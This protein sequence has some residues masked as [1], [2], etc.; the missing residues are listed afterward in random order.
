[1]PKTKS[2]R[3]RAYLVPHH[4]NEAKMR[5][6][7]DLLP[8]WQRGLV[9]MQHLQVRRMRAGIRPSN[10]STTGMPDYLSQRQWKSIVNQVNAG[11]RSWQA[12]VS[13]LMGRAIKALDVSDSERDR[14]KSLH[15]KR[16][17]WADPVLADLVSAIGRSSVPF[18]NF[19]RVRTMLMDGPIAQIEESR[20]PRFRWWIRFSLPTSPPVRVPIAGSPY[21][22]ANH[23][24]LRRFCQ[25]SVSDQGAVSIR[26]VKQS[27]IAEPRSTG[28]IVG[29]DWGLKNLLTTSNGRR[30]GQRLYAWLVTRDAEVTA[31]AGQL[32]RRQIK[33][34]DSTRF[35]ALTRR[36]REYVKNEIGRILNRI[37]DERI[38]EIAV[39]SLDFRGKGLSPAL[40]R[41]VT[42]AGR[43]ILKQRLA[44]LTEDRGITITEVSAAY[45][46]QTCSGCGFTHRSN[47]TSQ[48]GFRCRFCGKAKHADASA[49]CNIRKR[50]SS[51]A[52]S[53]F[54]SKSDVLAHLDRAFTSKWRITPD[55]L[56]ER[57][58]RPHSRA[59]SGAP[60]PESTTHVDE[61]LRKERLS[62]S[63]STSGAACS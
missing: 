12:I 9:H 22:E 15:A 3:V 27:T 62:V 1:M 46:S 6:L 20:S 34:R 39:E 47:R 24:E 44:A 13:P 40:R 4:G 58:E 53:P 26:L 33:P 63:Y 59:I 30:H 43:G 18:P 31:L 50:R 11:L 48:A 17:W 42:R 52:A 60:A 45:T 2:K 14:L 57:S 54:T 10:V 51:P 19:S 23:G 28:D 49:A 25:V 38:R 7:A 8:H 55:R 36:I 5:V 16:S 56:R 41:V 61:R 35:R 37:A 21:M 29:L 32:Q